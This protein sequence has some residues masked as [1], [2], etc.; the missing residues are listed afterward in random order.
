MPFLDLPL[1]IRLHVYSYIA[2]PT[3][4][5]FSDYYGFYLSCQQIKAEIDEEAPKIC[6]RFLDKFS[7]A[8]PGHLFDHG[9]TLPGLYDLHLTLY[10]TS[11]RHGVG[12]ESFKSILSL[13]YTSVTI[14]IKRPSHVLSGVIQ[15]AC[16]SQ[17]AVDLTKLLVHAD[18]PINVQRIVLKLPSM[19]PSVT[20]WIMREIGSRSSEIPCWKTTSKVE[21]PLV[22]VGQGIL[23]WN[24]CP[25]VESMKQTLL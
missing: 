10:Y 1:E 20:H 24:N 4:G 23:I 14:A 21:R 17:I 2:F 9:I 15:V 16:A 5:P 8:N 13:Y 19:D 18:E 25:T 6:R 11:G 22:E 3:S 12:V 7:L